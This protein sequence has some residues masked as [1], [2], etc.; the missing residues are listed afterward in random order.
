MLR[1]FRQLICLEA[2]YALP[3]ALVVLLLGSL[4]VIPSLSLMNTSLNANRVID[5]EDLGLYAADAGVQY[6][7]W[8]M[9]PE[10]EGAFELPDEGEDVSLDF[11]EVLN[12]RT[13]NIT[14]SNKG[15]RLYKITSH[16]M[17]SSGG[18]KEI[19]SY[20]EMIPAVE[21]A[22]GIFDYA[23]SSLDGDI[24]L[25]GSSSIT[26]EPAGD[27]D[28]Y[29]NGGGIDL[30]GSCT[31]DG[32]ATATGEITTTGSSYI[33]G[34]ETEGDT[35]PPAP[36]YIDVDAYINETLS[37]DCDDIPDA[38]SSW[39]NPAGEYIDP[40]R[41]IVDMQISGSGTW[42]FYDRVC[43]GRDMKISGST[44]VIFKG[45]VSVGR[46]VDISGTGTVTF[47]DTLY[48]GDD[49]KTSGNRDIDLLDTVYV[50]DEIQMTGSGFRGGTTIIAGGDI[51]LSGSGRMNDMADIPFLVSTNGDI[52]FTGSHVISAIVYAQNGDVKMTGSNQLYGCAVGMNVTMTGS[53]SIEY[54]VGIGDREDLPEGE[55]GGGS[56]AG[57]TIRTYTIN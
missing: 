41:V 33:T 57:L 47:E 10:Y 12:N 37:N 29:A 32:D 22:K 18:T 4:V 7:L 3:T 13:I 45:P 44:Q 27:G 43:I 40:V 38:V 34:L 35:D 36:P 39:S 53:T 50:A 46:D 51:Q 26:S 19:I 56:S 8:H 2:G 15:E 25:T 16:A 48:V 17:K 5:E 52:T 20:I 1:F 42:V 24:Q 30:T 14:I 49:L 23:V 9:R 11:P 31:V 55:G 21:G 6:A 54:P 28:I